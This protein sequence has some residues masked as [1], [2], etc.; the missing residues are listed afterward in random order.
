[1]KLWKA[2]L[3]ALLVIVIGGAVGGALL[4]RRG[5]RATSTPSRWEAAL[6]RRVRNLAIPA[7]QRNLKNPLASAGSSFFSFAACAP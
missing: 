3:L 7:S 4:I 1:M 6:A 5:F 2:I